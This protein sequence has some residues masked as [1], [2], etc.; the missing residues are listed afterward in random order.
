MKMVWIPQ[1]YVAKVLPEA[2][3]TFVYESFGFSSLLPSAH[4]PLHEQTWNLPEQ[5]SLGACL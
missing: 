5:W 1:R 3:A 4:V 2:Y